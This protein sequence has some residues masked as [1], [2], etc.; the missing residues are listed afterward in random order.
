MT[1]E[2]IRKNLDSMIALQVAASMPLRKHRDERDTEFV[3]R[4][5]ACYLAIAGQH[6]ATLA[7]ADTAPALVAAD[8]RNDAIEECAALLDR[9]AKDAKDAAEFCDDENC[10]IQDNVY[11]NAATAVRNLKGKP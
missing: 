7:Q 3:K 9:W 2:E 6:A 8:P 11:R 5:V 1:F 10:R 4:I